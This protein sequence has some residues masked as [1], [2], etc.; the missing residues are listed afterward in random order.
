MTDK[1]ETSNKDVKIDTLK[2]EVSD[3]G[4]LLED[5]SNELKNNEK[6]PEEEKKAKNDALKAKVD[7][8]K[9]QAETVKKKI[10][11]K[12]SALSDKTDNDS[13]KEKEEAETLLTSLN[14]RIA[15]K[16]SILNTWSKSIAETPTETT[17]NGNKWF[18]KSIWDWFTDKRNSFKNKDNKDKAKTVWLVAAWAWAVWLIYWLFWKK[19]RERRRQRREAKREAR[20]AA[21]EARRKE[22]DELPF[23]QR[24]FGRILKWTLIWSAVVWWGYL[25]L[26]HLWLIW[27]S[28]KVDGKSSDE[29]KLNWYENEVVNK[30]ENKEKF[31]IYEDFGEN[32]DTLYWSI[33]DRE[34]KS[35]YEDELEMQKIAQEQSDWEKHYKWIVP[36]CLDNQFKNIENILWQNSS[37][38]NAIANWLQWMTDYIKSKWTDFLQLFVDNY[39][40]KLTSWTSLNLTWSLS[41]KIE[42]WRIENKKSQQELQYFFR[43]SIRIQT[44]LFEKRDQLISKI[45]K[46]SSA[47]YGISEKDIL[48]NDENFKKYVLDTQEYQSFNNSPI[49]SAVTILR[50]YD[51][52][53]SE[54]TEEKKEEVKELD[55][56]RNEVLWCKEWEK[57]ILQIIN[58]KK[59]RWE[60]L[61][62]EENKALEK[63][64]DG[65]V[66]DVDDR[67]LEAVE[68]SA[69]HIY[70]DLRWSEDSHLREYLDKSWLEKVFQSYKQ[71]ILQK[72]L[73]LKEWK[74][75]NEDK[76][77]LA[78]SINAMLALKKEA[79]IW[80]QTI[81]KDYDEN[82]N[83]IYRIPGFLAWSISNLCKWVWKLFTHWEFLDGLNYITSAWL[84]TGLVITGAWVIYG[85]KTGKWWVARV[86]AKITILPA[87]IW[88]EIGNGTINMIK[89]LRDWI[90]KLNYPFK[91]W[92]EKWPQKLM[93]LLKDGKISLNKASEIAKWKT[94]DTILSKTT[95]KRRKDFFG[96]QNDDNVT[97]KVFNKLV[98]EK[99]GTAVWATY[100]QSMKDNDIYE[101]LVKN[102]DS[103]LEIRRAI[104]ESASIEELRRVAEQ[105]NVPEKIRNNPHY[106]R[107]S[108]DLD[109][110]ER[111][112]LRGRNIDDLADSERQVLD[113]ISGL[114]D[115]IKK[116]ED[117]K[118]LERTAELL[119]EFKWWKWWM[120]WLWHAVEQFTTLSKLEGKVIDTWILDASDNPVKKNLDD[121]LKNMDFAELRTYK[122]KIL[123]LWISDVSDE[124]IES[125]AKTF[126]AIKKSRVLKFN[127][128]MKEIRNAIKTLVKCLAKVS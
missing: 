43:Q 71:T 95:E 111:H 64:C 106:K 40:S 56:Q 28:D 8:I 66:K 1:K 96:V 120:S 115:A 62:G 126:E 78:E 13:V 59:E 39:L 72:K 75:S 22:I 117:P 76:I 46:E 83:I 45:V 17:D 109:L 21:R 25:L 38:K 93:D 87:W 92:W 89:P 19:A 27:K 36:Y 23:W 15:L 60:A 113:N 94:L 119:T 30:P 47:K 54:I 97:H 125:L 16:A 88:Y 69:R 11:A 80:S 18:F 101:T 53:D 110:L 61:T 118:D 79:V 9:T 35:W 124:A 55:N 90:D 34:L 103:S 67:I 7:T 57:D 33:Y 82:G 12:I 100:I 5:L 14:K 127:D 10:E 3:I 70:W 2:L 85:I 108:S 86:W 26:K 73:E 128:C 20:R 114:R 65:I 42:K 29:E 6:L 48:W 105:S 98:T 102:Y 4:K 123:W 121:I 122:S 44:Y 50:N 68:E 77:A 31:E 84:W 116:M 91:F 63:A 104:S 41:E 112:T 32:I 99:S 49:S 51:I 81:E 37:M 52:F 58:E 24:P 107:L 74:L